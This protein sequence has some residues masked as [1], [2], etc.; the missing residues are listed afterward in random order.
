MLF[1]AFEKTP[2]YAAATFDADARRS[3]VLGVFSGRTSSK[4][5]RARPGRLRRLSE[6][7]TTRIHQ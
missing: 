7:S 3:P 6:I 4:W 1:L 2:I 5:N